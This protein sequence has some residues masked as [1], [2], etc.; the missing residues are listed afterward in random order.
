MRRED[1][2]DAEAASRAGRVT[3]ADTGRPITAFTLVP[4][5]TWEKIQNVWWLN[6][7]AKEVTGLSYDVLLST[8]A[9]LS[10]I[11]IE[12]E[13]YLPETSRGMKDDE[14]DAVVH[15]ALTEGPVSRA[16]SGCPTAPA[17]G[18]RR[19][20][21]HAGAAASVEQRPTP[22]RSGRPAPGSPGGR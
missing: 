16:S 13:G 18:G 4:G 21:R 8:D 6:D 11:R 22:P 3:D 7:R 9:G 1:Y 19:A 5:F 14:E 12:A 10:V 2:P 15:F 20:A 17:G